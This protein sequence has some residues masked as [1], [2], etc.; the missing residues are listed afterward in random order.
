MLFED[1]SE[2]D[3]YKLCICY[4]G[5][6]ADLLRRSARQFLCVHYGPIMGY[7]EGLAYL[8]WVAILQGR[9]AL[10]GVADMANAHIPF[11]PL[12][13]MGVFKVI[14]EEA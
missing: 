3:A 13:F 6:D 8:Y 11:H 5:R 2:P 14:H 10:R 4:W 12:N 1:L 7:E 9:A